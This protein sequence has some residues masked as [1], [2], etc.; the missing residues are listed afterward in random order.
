MRPAQARGLARFRRL[1]LGQLPL[2]MLANAFFC[3]NPAYALLVDP[4]PPQIYNFYGGVGLIDMPSA[5]FDRDGELSFTVSST[6]TMD[7]YNLGFQALPWLEAE[8]RYARID[9]YAIATEGDLYDR[10]LGFKIRLLQE[11]DSQPSLAVGAQ[12]IL[13]TGA[14]GAE[15]LV[16]SKRWGDFDFTGG[17]GWRRFSGT[18]SF[19][20]PFALLFSSFKNITGGPATGG[21]PR[22][23]DFFHGQHA[24]LFGGITWQSPIDG[25]QLIAELSGDNF[26]H[27]REVGSIDLKSALNFG[28]SYEPWRGVQIGG[29]YMYGSQFGVR[30]T[31]HGNA[32][33]P[34]PPVRIGEQPVAPNIRSAQDRTDAVLGLVQDRAPV[35]SQIVTELPKAAPVQAPSLADAIFGG[36]PSYH[37]SDVE[38][39]G[40]SLIAEVNSPAGLPACAKLAEVLTSARSAGFT[41][42]AFVSSRNG[43]TKICNANEARLASALTQLRSAELDDNNDRSQAI[44]DRDADVPSE[45]APPPADPSA[46]IVESA[47]SQGI[48]IQSII[49]GK[50]RV[51]VAFIN[52]HYRTQ[53]EAIGRLLRILMAMTPD[54]VEE[55]RLVNILA[56]MPTTAVLIRR[57]D[58]ERILENSGSAV[59]LLPA[60]DFSNDPIGDPVFDEHNQLHYPQFNWGVSPGYSQSLFDPK[61]PYLFQIYANLFGSVDFDEHFSVIA[62]IEANIYNNFNSTGRVSNSQLPHVRTDFEEYYKHGA[63]GIGALEVDYTT[64]LGPDIYARARAGYLESMYAGVGGEV[65]WRPPHSRWAFGADLYDV[66]QRAFDRLFGFRNYETLTGHVGVYYKSPFYDLDFSVLAGRY[67]AKDYGATFEVVRQFPSGIQVGFY[68]TLTNVPFSVFGE[69]SFD[70]GFILRI[71]LDYIAPVNTQQMAVLD[72]SPLTRDGGQRLAGDQNLYYETDPSSEGRML[73]NW[74]HV[75]HP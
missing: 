3:S 28:F 68:A 51:E 50:R 21:A 4:N 31:L 71:P 33:A 43:E 19:E 16:A 29:A 44:A 34:E 13:G 63:T 46:K 48:L 54:E 40:N 12:D 11:T 65:L 1:V 9:R 64:K 15:Y 53:T 37:F 67:L 30:V 8:F 14:F 75:I 23:G 56:G 45:P 72:F 41:Q 32:F 52:A 27:E 10:S 69:G 60:T 66:K 49:L 26:H 25:L 58:I 39:Y 55:F 7:R 73:E 47:R 20:N 18:F 70:K 57:S 35:Y 62:D 74:D 61:A 6:P 17:I 59:E 42:I 24:G 2:T 38:S 36:R 22:L 5:R